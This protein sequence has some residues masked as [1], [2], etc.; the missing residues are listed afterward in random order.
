MT[1]ELTPS[2]SSLQILLKDLKTDN[3]ST[4]LPIRLSITKTDLLFINEY[5]SSE[6]ISVPL[7]HPSL[8]KINIL[9]KPITT[10]PNSCLKCQKLAQSKSKIPK[11]SNYDLTLFLCND[12]Y[13]KQT[14]CC[15]CYM[16]IRGCGSEYCTDCRRLF[17]Y[18]K[19][20]QGCAGCG[21]TYC[22]D[23]KHSC[24]GC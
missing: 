23:C 7:S 13:C 2:N 4:T 1:L 14:K 8:D 15:T 6:V 18:P 20:I 16:E 11:F 19:H 21:N 17:C 3:V 12:C 9:R 22:D 5:D 24:H 10:S